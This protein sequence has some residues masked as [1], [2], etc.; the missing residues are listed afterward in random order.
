MS[1]DIKRTLHDAAR[2]PRLPIDPDGVRSRG[3]RRRTTRL[4]GGSA[5]A[6]LLVIGGVAALTN[7]RPTSPPVIS[8]VPAPA[9]SN[10]SGP[11]TPTPSPSAT[12]TATGRS[13]PVVDAAA[14]GQSIATATDDSSA[15]L[16]RHPDGTSDRVELGASNSGSA[17]WFPA[18]G[19]L[20]WQ[21]RGNDIGTAPV[22]FTDVEG[23]TTV[24]VDATDG[25]AERWTLVGA[26]LATRSN[27][28]GFE[29]ASD[30]LLRLSLDGAATVVRTAVAGWESAVTEVV[31]SQDLLWSLVV[32]A[33]SYAIHSPSSGDSVMVYEGGESSGT[34]VQG[35]TQT[36][37]GL[38]AVLATPGGSFPEFPES[39]LLLV[40]L[41]GAIIDDLTPPA[42]LGTD[43]WNEPRVISGGDGHI[44]VNRYAEGR[45][46][47]ALVL[48]L[49]SRT[50]SVLDTPGLSRFTTA[51]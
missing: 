40:D 8:P 9:A 38:R 26:G 32:E 42:D 35:V 2:R 25:S 3:R 17:A 50:W 49:E 31:G 47:A 37:D 5:L 4:A 16:F 12:P 41:D 28:G 14:L 51:Q 13:H 20:W 29:T 48:D 11:V 45:W 27:G 15:V 23:R 43:T 36:A 22:H 18:D 10:T 44:L 7:S 33:G 6:L 21:D 30:D 1:P 19:G 24:V 34:F 46:L 39:H